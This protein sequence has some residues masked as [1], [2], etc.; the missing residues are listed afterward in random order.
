MNQLSKQKSIK[1]IFVSLSIVCIPLFAEMNEH[2]RRLFG[3][4]TLPLFVRHLDALT[5]VEVDSDGKV[6]DIMEAAAAVLPIDRRKYI[7]TYQGQELHPNDGIADSGLSAESVLDLTPNPLYLYLDDAMGDLTKC[8]EFRL[9]FDANK[10]RIWFTKTRTCIRND[11]IDDAKTGYLRM[12]ETNIESFKEFQNHVNEY[13]T[14][15]GF[16]KTHSRIIKNGS[17]EIYAFYSLQQ[18]SLQIAVNKEPI[19]IKLGN[20]NTFHLICSHSKR[21]WQ[22]FAAMVAKGRPLFFGDDMLYELKNTS[23][24]DAHG[25]RTYQYC[26]NGTL[27][28]G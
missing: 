14:G 22:Q 12:N 21:R 13:V 16:T 5:I 28:I 8:I 9:K 20:Q 25:V 2:I 24:F 7:L 19:S 1:G 27:N 4:A 17:I 18:I 10:K 3:N 6:R 23:A 11:G 15:Q 26:L